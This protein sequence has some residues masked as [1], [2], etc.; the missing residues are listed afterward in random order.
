MAEN[1]KRTPLYQEHVAAGAKIVPFAGYEMPVQ[2]KSGIIA[3]H[4]AVRQRAGLFDVS[5]MGE[6]ELRGPQALELVQYVTTN[7]ASK[8]E[9]GQAQY[10]V[11][12][13]EDGGCIDDCSEK[14]EH[15]AQQDKDG[16]NLPV[17]RTASYKAIDQGGDRQRAY[18]QPVQ[19][20]AEVIGSQKGRGW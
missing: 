15:E 17:F 11:I 20:F 3:E 5:H 10:S 14:S 2:Y 19:D 6:L 1:L 4:Q 8:L 13:R 18:Y 9:V 16:T 7:D 12:C